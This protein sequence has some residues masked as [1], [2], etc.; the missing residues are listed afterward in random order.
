MKKQLVILIFLMTILLL[1]TSCDK[2]NDSHE[3]LNAKKSDSEQVY[4][5][6][7]MFYR[8]DLKCLQTVGKSEEQILDLFDQIPSYYISRRLYYNID[9]KVKDSFKMI[10]D[11]KFLYVQ[12]FYEKLPEHSVS[13]NKQHIILLRDLKNDSPIFSC[14]VIYQQEWPVTLHIKDS[15]QGVMENVTSKISEADD[16][17]DAIVKIPLD[18]LNLDPANLQMN[19]LRIDWGANPVTSYFP[20]E[21]SYFYDYSKSIGLCMVIGRQGRMTDVKFLDKPSDF[22]TEQQEIKL[23]CIGVNKQQ[24]TVS[25]KKDDYNL[26]FESPQGTVTYPDVSIKRQKGN[27]ILTFE[28]PPV[29][30]DGIYRIRLGDRKDTVL[31]VEKKAF[32]EAANSGLIIEEIEKTDVDISTLSNRAKTLLELV[33]PYIG[34]SNLPD[35][36]DT[37][38]WPYG[39]YTYNISSPDKIKSNKTGDLYPS[40]EFPENEVYRFDN[41]DGNI[42]EYPYYITEDGIDCFFTPAVRNRQGNHVVSALPELAKSDPA[43]AAHVLAELSE[44]YKNYAPSIDH[45]FTV[46]PVPMEAGPPYPYYGGLWT[47]WF[48]SDARMAAC[49]AEAYAEVSKTNALEKLSLQTGKDLDEQILFMIQSTVDYASSFGPQNSNMDY[50][51]WEGLIR[52]GKALQQPDYIHYALEKIYSFIK[53]NYLFDGFWREVTVSYHNQITVGLYNVLGLLARYTDPEGYVYPGTGKRMENFKFTNQYPILK[54]SYFLSSLL[55]Y[56]NGK[57]LPVQDSH[58]SDKGT[59]SADAFKNVLMPASGI[60][61]LTGNTD[62]FKTF[63]TQAVLTYVPKYGHVHYDTLNLNLFGYGVE[64]LPDLGYTHT[65]NRSWVTSTLSHNTV[66]VNSKDSQSTHVGNTLRFIPSDH[67][68]GVVRASDSLAYH[69]TDVYDREVIYV[70]VNDNGPEGYVLDLFRVSGGDRHEYSLNMSADYDNAL[71]GDITWQKVS[72]TMLPEGV[73]YIKPTGETDSGSA[74]GHYTSYMHVT[75]VKSAEL[76]NQSYQISYSI[77][78]DSLYKNVGLNIFGADITGE[79]MLG[80]APSMRLTRQSVNNDLNDRCDDYMMDKLVLRREGQSLSSCF[81][82]LLEPF[83]ERYQATVNKVERLQTDGLHEFDVIAK[84]TAPEFT[85]YIFSAF[86]EDMDITVD[87]IR[88]KGQFGYVR[89]KDGKAIKMQCSNADVLSYDGIDAPENRSISGAI[90]DVLVESEGDPLNGFVIDVKPDEGLK[91]QY[92]IIKHP[93]QTCTGYPITEI[94]EKDGTYIVDIGTA[95][96]G[97]YFTGE[98]QTKMMFYPHIEREGV[99][100]FTIDDTR[101]VK[102]ES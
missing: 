48:Y 1:F 25:G 37:Q 21:H 95:E 87:N 73:S 12:L 66:I 46:Y 9:T 8:A 64:L 38:L 57:H 32:I 18:S 28:H 52:I 29:S 42:I 70:P 43:G 101:I 100:E 54:T 14:T 83:S 11:E 6:D 78:Q 75:D 74:S 45:Y 7:T 89:I 72:K 94:K 39:I 13:R 3:D 5:H 20:I 56:P 53:N 55:A 90:K 17:Y 2:R 36:K 26:A 47:G 51:H 77:T 62:L 80:K 61:R 50:A 44:K 88:F 102:N 23:E 49:I 63:G 19:V 84:V 91:G 10:K 71:T 35:P 76:K 41:G 40:D 69:E 79:L 96:P 4:V 97:F 65:R 67:S 24:I 22:E 31:Y 15:S 34:I 59:S 33:P 98:Q 68:V 82:T 30:E 58:A 85:D 27:D 81:V 16:G 99:I 92:I 86:E 93:D 60:A